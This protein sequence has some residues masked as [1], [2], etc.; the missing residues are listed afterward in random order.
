MTYKKILCPGCNLPMLNGQMFN[1]M[2]GCHWDCTDKV[3]EQERRDNPRPPTKSDLRWDELKKSI[4][5]VGNLAIRL[6]TENVKM[7]A[8][9]AGLVVLW[10]ADDCVTGSPQHGHQVPG[11]WDG[12][13]QHPKG[14]T[15]EECAVYDAVRAMVAGKSGKARDV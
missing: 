1:G 8:I 7:L 2:W 13:R 10:D 15:C 11:K 6:E 9:M 5:E 3:R 14:S 4:D 12:D